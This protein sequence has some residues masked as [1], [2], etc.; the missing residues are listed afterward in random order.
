MSL[1]QQSKPEAF[2][3][4]ATKRWVIEASAGTGKTYTIENLVIELVLEANIPLEKIVIVTYTEAASLELRRRIREKLQEMLALTKDEIKGEKDPWKIND[5]ARERLSTALQSFDRTVISTI[6]AFCQKI[7][8]DGSFETG[9]FFY[10]ERVDENE[11]FAGVFREFLRT[12]YCATNKDT[13]FLAQALAWAGSP[14]ELLKILQGAWS[15]QAIL[16]PEAA[17]LDDLRQACL[18][19]PLDQLNQA[20]L[21]EATYGKGSYNAA[22]IRFSSLH[23]SLQALRTKESLGAWVSLINNN[24]FEDISDTGWGKAVWDTPHPPGPAML[25]RAGLES[26]R[27]SLTTPESIVIQRLLPPLKLEVEARKAKEGLYDFNDMIDQ[28]LKGIQNPDLTER[29]RSRYEAALID[30]F[31]DTD[32]RQWEIFR[33]IFGTKA[34]RLYLVGDPKQAIYDFRGGDLPTYLAARDH[35]LHQKDEEG[36]SLPLDK[37]YRSSSALVQAVNRV[38]EKEGDFFTLPNEY[39]NP[40]SSARATTLK[41]EEAEHP[42]VRLLKVSTDGKIGRIRNQIAIGIASYFR[43]LI[44]SG[45]AFD[46][47]K[48]EDPPRPLHAG[49]LMVL[50]YSGNEAKLIA[51]ALRE[52]SLPFTFF[53]A[54]GLFQSREALELQ[55][56]L[57]AILRPDDPDARGKALLTRFFGLGLPEAEACL[58]LPPD[59]SVLTRLERWQDLASDRRYPRLFNLIMEESGIIR[60][61]LLT[62]Q[63][64]RALTNFRHITEHLLAQASASHPGL[65]DLRLCLGR[66]IREEDLPAE[67]DEAG[68]QRA[69]GHSKAVRILTIHKAKGL[70]APVVALF[71]GYGVR[72]QQKGEGIRFHNS[73]G[74]RCLFLGQRKSMP[75]DIRD[76]SDGESRQEEERKLYVAITRPK[77]QLVLPV[78]EVGKVNP[79][80]K[81]G[82]FD[83]DGHP[84]GSYGLLHRR[85]RDLMGSN[86]EQWGEWAIPLP[87]A[88]EGQPE[89]LPPT[90][91]GHITMPPSPVLPD[92]PGLSRN[93]RPLW[94]YSFSSLTRAFGGGTKAVV[95]ENASRADE[96]ETRPPSKSSEGLP[97]SAATGLALHKL[98]ELIPQ[99]MVEVLGEAAWREQHLP[100][101][102]KCLNKQGIDPVYAEEALDMAFLAL[103]TQFGL[104][105]GPPVILDEVAKRQ[106]EVDF[107]MPF[108]DHPDALEGSIDLLFEWDGRI[109]VLDW[110]SNALD[111]DDYSPDAVGN[112]VASHYDLQVRIY[113]LVA[114]EIWKIKD[115]ATFEARFGGAVYIYLRG[116]PQGG[117]WSRRPSWAEV[118]SW[119]EDLK[120]L[121]IEELAL[122]RMAWGMHG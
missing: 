107:Q 53:K 76:L 12:N 9:R 22:K 79:P 81:R 105:V 55:D 88:R 80:D 8:Q 14:D 11:M 75:Q 93:G 48:K 112:S 96:V 31:Q 1:V 97:S 25:I 86:P 63:G 43:S 32:A 70:D 82:V 17:A 74:Q 23:G 47:G 15:S 122:N 116:L 30:E 84:E 56:L 41:H 108:P 26:L 16:V 52:A 71:G 46:S 106:S 65:E 77:V 91:P 61:L 38:L 7:L 110:K 101:A 27:D 118:M 68:L 37:N 64:D 117:N 62:E 29:L 2:P 49:D 10:Q 58:E 35:L 21:L 19:F 109:Y 28:V 113:T 45:P 51:K 67:T 119:R 89:E 83:T 87:Q 121:K 6:H 5:E 39:P 98:L 69:E 40:V 60:R 114:L 104:P 13:D 34:H 78:F 4:L 44:D 85:L 95:H 24:L 92:F 3:D 36:R 59:N 102:V 120:S 54:D 90:L 94:L 18:D 73:L 66:W 42:P 33:T 50:T 103:T 111:D 100:L 115:E 72:P 57:G 20:T 99:G